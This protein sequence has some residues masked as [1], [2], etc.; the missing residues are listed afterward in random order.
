MKITVNEKN[1]IK[2]LPVFEDE[3]DFFEKSAGLD[4]LVEKEYFTGKASE[5]FAKLGEDEIIYLGLGKKNEITTK[6]IIVAFFE[7]A[8]ALR[9][10]KIKD[11]NI[12][13]NK[14]LDGL[15]YKTTM[16]AIVDGLA[17]F[18]YDFDKYLSDD[19]KPTKLG[20]I[21]IEVIENKKDKAKE[22]VEEAI[23]IAEG[24]SLTKD[25]VNTPAIDMY[26]EVLANRAK[27]DLEPLGVTVEIYG[28]KEIEELGMKA[29]LAVA[30]GSD[31]EPKLIV[32]KYMNGES[33][34]KL[35]ALVGKGLTYDSGGYCIK[36]PQGMATMHMDMGGA[37]AVI[38]AMHAIAKN[39]VKKNVVAVVASCE[40]LIS[41][42]AYKTGD[43]IGSMSGKTIEVANTDAEGR[44]TL[45]DAI[46]Y[47]C[48]VLK[49]DRV[50]DLATLT[51][52][53]VVALGSY[54]T[55][56]VTNNDEFMNEMN[57]AAKRADEKLWLMP[58]D[59]EYKDMVKGT[60]TDLLNSVPGGAGMITAGMFLE[61]FVKEGTPWIH[62]DIAGTSDTS[63]DFAQ[64]KKGSTG[65]P[66]KTLYYLINSEHTC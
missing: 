43:L 53:C 37:G 41:G 50:V 56:V 2:V 48:D 45:A 51:G 12:I 59:D 54:R 13:F 42:K 14:K 16:K 3:R 64:Y 18:D 26:P 5:V 65:V 8:K 36:N 7:L 33:G 20:T 9:K 25:L 31:K 15:C 19:N 35:T 11:A 28:K 4:A 62:M 30:V 44:L 39:K 52:A 29:F 24:Y 55:G 66:V 46:Y 34:D 40:N 58:N 23:N 10:Y 6:K 49:A 21:N 27:E 60:M 61:N 22:A 57:E 38:G 1:G 63:K 17:C 47:A 32:M